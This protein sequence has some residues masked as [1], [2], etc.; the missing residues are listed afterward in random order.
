M[1]LHDASGEM[2]HRTSTCLHQLRRCVPVVIAR[3]FVV[4]LCMLVASSC[5]SPQF[6]RCCYHVHVSMHCMWLAVSCRLSTDE[7]AV[8]AVCGEG[9]S[10]APNQILFCER[11]DLAVHQLCYGLQHIP[12]GE[13]LCCPCKAHEEQLAKQGVPQNQ[14]RPPRYDDAHQFIAAAWNITCLTCTCLLT[15]LTIIVCQICSTISSGAK[16]FELFLPHKCHCLKAACNA[17]YYELLCNCRWEMGVGDVHKPL[18]GGSLSVECALC[19]VRHGAFK[20]TE[21]GKHW[22]HLVCALW[23]PET[24]ANQSKCSQLMSYDKG[25][26]LAVTKIRFASCPHE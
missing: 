14:I 24:T 21:D 15:K 4:L 8:C 7:D 26:C 16:E 22:V 18:G 11:C 23:H 6:I 10:E 12:E 19:P 3:C 1:Q 20:K 5:V 13:W 25:L 9:H 17:H 2:N